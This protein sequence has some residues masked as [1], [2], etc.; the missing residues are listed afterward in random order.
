MRSYVSDWGYLWFPCSWD[1][2][3]LNVLRA[4]HY[5]ENGAQLSEMLLVWLCPPV[6][7]MLGVRWVDMANDYQVQKV[8]ARGRIRQL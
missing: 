3:H 2:P 7:P 4:P 6:V 1:C 5:V 8:L